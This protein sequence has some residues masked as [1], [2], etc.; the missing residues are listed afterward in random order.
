MTSFLFPAP[1]AQIQLCS[2]SQGSPRQG[3]PWGG[4]CTWWAKPGSPWRWAPD[5]RKSRPPTILSS[6]CVLGSDSQPNGET[7]GQTGLETADQF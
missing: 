3:L 7:D 5:L 2:A 4:G 6:A 1:E